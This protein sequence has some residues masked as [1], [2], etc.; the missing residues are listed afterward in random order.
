MRSHR[1]PAGYPLPKE[2]LCDAV[3]NAEWLE[4]ASVE[5]YSLERLSEMLCTMKD[6]FRPYFILILRQTIAQFASPSL[7]GSHVVVEDELE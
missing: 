6:V 2:R 5:L 4:K 1:T 3:V 7:P